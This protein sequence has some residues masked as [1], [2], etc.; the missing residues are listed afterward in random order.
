M[1]REY[2]PP[3]SCRLSGWYILKN[4]PRLNLT[5]MDGKPYV[6]RQCRVVERVDR[7][8]NESELTRLWRKLTGR[9]VIKLPAPDWKFAVI[10]VKDFERF[11]KRI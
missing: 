7:L 11:F 3:I 2:R 8:S 1:G 9:M 10:K 5:T 4:R 6:L